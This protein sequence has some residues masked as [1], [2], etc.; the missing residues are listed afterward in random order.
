MVT[1]DPMSIVFPVGQRRFLRVKEQGR[2]TRRQTAK[3]FSVTP[4]PLSARGREV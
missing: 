2:G 3:D 1:T 4:I